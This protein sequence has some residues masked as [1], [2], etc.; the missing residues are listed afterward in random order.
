MREFELNSCGS[1]YV[2]WYDMT[3]EPAWQLS[4]E[5]WCMF[6]YGALEYASLREKWGS[7]T[8]LLGGVGQAIGR[9]VSFRGSD[10]YCPIY[11]ASRLIIFV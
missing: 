11:L 6:F 5:F 10:I 7:L 3:A 2:R 1:V 9:S 4:H 8:L